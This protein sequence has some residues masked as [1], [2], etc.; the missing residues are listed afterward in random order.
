MIQFLS[1]FVDNIDIKKNHF[2]TVQVIKVG[3]FSREISYSLDSKSLFVVVVVV[4]HW[5]LSW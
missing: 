4:E 5:F 3:I 1:Y 2:L